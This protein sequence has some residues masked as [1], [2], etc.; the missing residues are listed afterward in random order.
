MNKDL[1]K[2]ALY[3]LTY[4][5]LPLFLMLTS[6]RDL[7]IVALLVPF[8]LFFIILFFTFT[9]LIRVFSSGVTVRKRRITAGAMAM[10]PVLLLL[11]QSIGQL[12]LRDVTIVIALMT[13]IV[14]YVMRSDIVR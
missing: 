1:R 5:S 3:A 11:L 13:I 2:I 10:F 8:L 14:F 12:S 4:A 6:P 7:P 9:I